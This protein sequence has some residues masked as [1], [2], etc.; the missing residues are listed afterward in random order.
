MTAEILLVEPDLTGD[1]SL[2]ERA[3]RDIRRLIVTLELAPGAVISEPELQDQLGMGRTPIREALRRL[4][5]EHLVEVYPRR[6]MFVAALDTRDLTAISELREELE[7]FAA[8][9]AAERRT[10]EDIAVIDELVAAM[11]ATGDDPDMRD[12]IELDQRVHHHVY[13]CAHN[14]Y[15]R[16]VLEQHYMHALRIWFLALDKVT[17]LHQAMAEN[18]DLLLAIRDGD[19]ALAESIMSSHVEGFEADVRRAI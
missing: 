8:R 12:L 18:R 3:Y 17:H 16:A 15:V 4:A 6:G 13:R 11:S 9:L 2:A 5:N 1:E 7:P 10:E 19:A 14:E